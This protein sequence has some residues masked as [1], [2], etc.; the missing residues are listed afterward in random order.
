MHSYRTQMQAGRVRAASFSTCRSA[1]LRI[2]SAV[3]R[4][5]PT[6]ERRLGSMMS[7][8]HASSTSTSTSVNKRTAATKV[9]AVA[10]TETVEAPTSTTSSPSKI[11]QRQLTFSE[12]EVETRFASTTMDRVLTYSTHAVAAGMLVCGFSGGGAAIA[13]IAAVLGYLAADAASGIFHWATDNY[14]DGRTPVFGDVIVKFQ[15]HHLQPWTITYRDWENNVAPI[16]KG[17]LAPAA[18]LL[19]LAAVGVLPPALSAFLGSFLGFV[20]NSQEFHKWSHTTNDNN[21][22][23]VVRLLQSCG[24]LVSRKEHGAHHK[25]PFEGHYCIVSGLMN[26]P[27]D[28]SGFF[29]KLETAIHERTGVKP[30]C[31]NEP[32]YTFLE[33]PHNQA[34]RIQ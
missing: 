6:L 31:W 5:N 33:E 23:P 4:R 16:C 32:D 20:V 2:P 15:G 28:G 25:P 10:G 19:A 34:W 24:I 18:A 8:I 14:G 13:A 7:R 27:L 17:A 12:E 11:P 3:V 21:L 1:H 29:K 22:P 9:N 30:R 26:A